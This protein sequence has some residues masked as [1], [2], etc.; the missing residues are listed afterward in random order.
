MFHIL[1]KIIVIISVILLVF[2]VAFLIG[3]WYHGAFAS[4]KKVTLSKRNRLYLVTTDQTCLPYEVGNH[5]Q[6]LDSLLMHA[7]ISYNR[8][9]TLFRY[10]PLTVKPDSLLSKGAMIVDDSIAV[11]SPL[12]LLNLPERN[13]AI[14]SIEAHPL[15]APYKTYP[16]I[17]RWLNNNGY[18][19][20][21]AL[22]I[23]EYYA[24][25]IVEIEMP[26]VVDSLQTHLPLKEQ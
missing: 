17:Q 8:E 7:N 5:V 26:V 9:V 12:V 22:P 25:G 24:R 19:Y 14:A 13:A 11:D 2:F 10:N 20:N 15:I 21:R 6:Y 4:V 1:K 16:A 23:I 18:R 3:A